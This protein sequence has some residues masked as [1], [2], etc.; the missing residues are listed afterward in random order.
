MAK[1]R[2]NIAEFLVQNYVVLVFHDNA[3]S[4][5]QAFRVKLFNGHYQE[6]RLV[7]IVGATEMI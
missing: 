1:R 7:S 4:S 5:F 3:C 2:L 6:I